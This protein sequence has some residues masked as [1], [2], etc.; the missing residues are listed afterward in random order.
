VLSTGPTILD[1][2][3][4]LRAAVDRLGAAP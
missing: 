4:L 3:E 1:T 2:V